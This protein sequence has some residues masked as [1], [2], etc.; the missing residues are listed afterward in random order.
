MKNIFSRAGRVA[1]VNQRMRTFYPELWKERKLFNKSS[2]VDLQDNIRNTKEN[3]RF[4]TAQDKPNV[5][6][7]EKLNKKLTELEKTKVEESRWNDERIDYW[8]VR[9]N[10]RMNKRFRE[11]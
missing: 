10:H 2:I 5:K 6:R 11:K 9:K 3:L 7:I 1:N 4:E 8:G